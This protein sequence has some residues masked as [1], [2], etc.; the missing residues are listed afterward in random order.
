MLGGVRWP[1]QEVHTHPPP[2]ASTLH[3]HSPAFP[4]L[5]PGRSLA[6]CSGLSFPVCK[7]SRSPWG[8]LREGVTLGSATEA[9]V[10][11]EGPWQ[12]HIKDCQAP[13]FKRQVAFHS[14]HPPHPPPTPS[15][16]TQGLLL[17]LTAVTPGEHGD[18]GEV[19]SAGQS[20]FRPRWQQW[21]GL[22][23]GVAGSGK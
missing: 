6:V 17:L 23:Q 20:P 3:S 10:L 14:F 12:L 15:F 9:A 19:L 22:T 18:C 21:Q 8:A 5:S 13:Q 1:C 2:P 11:S 16:L 4:T 7:T